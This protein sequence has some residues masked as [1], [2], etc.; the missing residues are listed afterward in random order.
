MAATR[1]E[2]VCILLWHEVQAYVRAEAEGFRDIKAR[3]D[4]AI[5]HRL[6]MLDQLMVFPKVLGP[7]SGHRDQS[8][9][10]WLMVMLDEASFVGVFPYRQARAR[11]PPGLDYLSV[12][13]RVR[14][15]PFKQ[16]EDQS[17]YGV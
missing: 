8:S 6:S 1:S 17:V 4:E 16:V 12:R 11:R 10:S 15:D 14:T 2:E 13:P 7:L 5:S 3:T 9:A